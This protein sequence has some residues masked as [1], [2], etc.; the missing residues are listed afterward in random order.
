MPDPA[1]GEQPV[2]ALIDTLPEAEA[3]LAF[4][5]HLDDTD[6]LLRLVIAASLAGISILLLL[7][8]RLLIS[9]RLH[10]LE[11]LPSGRF[12]ALRW[13]AQDLVSAEEM[14][15]FWLNVWRG[16]SW[17]LS[18]VLGVAALIGVLL[19]S[20][21]TMSLAVQLILLVYHAL[22]YVWTGFVSYLPNLVTIAVILVVARYT[23]RIIGLVFDGIAGRRI[24]IRN[25]YPE[26]AH[27]SFGLIRLLIYALTAVIIFPYLPGSSSPAFQGI[28]IFVGVLVSLGSTT[29]VANVVAGV[30][31]T[32]T[33][34]FQVGDQVTV[35]DVRGRVVERSTFVTRIQTL[36]NVI[37]S[38]PNSMVL[39]NNVINY[40][41]NM[42]Q[43]G[44]LVHSCISI[45]YDVPWQ[46]VNEL[47]ISAARRTRDI[48]SHP[49]PFVLQVSLEDNYVVYEVNGWTRK[50]GELPRIYSELHANI[51]DEFHGHKIEITSPAY[52]A[53]RDGNAPAIAS[54]IVPDEP[55]QD[56][57]QQPA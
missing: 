3:L 48:S 16:V 12:K 33:R 54:V 1:V 6:P 9:R 57:G 49:E 29:A 43:T 52:R 15:H 37:V 22:E 36:K 39:N 34:A 21:W 38:I 40:S 53:V 7:L 31:L 14:K 44:L 19:T 55:E 30:V 18:L 17:L 46:T 2:E 13:Q 4:F 42:G 27:T 32:Y 41:K 10:F 47:L 24:H 51:L 8:A 56:G 45:G 28:S 5:S 26:W 35:S 11:E 23:I 25:F 50:S 20:D